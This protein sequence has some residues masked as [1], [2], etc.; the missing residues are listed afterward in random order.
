M[1]YFA[2]IDANN[3]VVTVIAVEEDSEHIDEYVL[4]SGVE[5]NPKMM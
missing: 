1:K 2:N 5:T 4:P 3:L